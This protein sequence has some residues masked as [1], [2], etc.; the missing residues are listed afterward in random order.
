M[1]SIIIPTYNE[2]KNIKELIPNLFSERND[3]EVI[4]VDDNSPDGTGKTAENLAK[5]YNVKVISREEK[6]DLSS[7]V[8]DGFRVA[9]SDVIGVMDAD[10]SHPYSKIGE[11]IELTIDYDLVIGSRS[12][13]GGR[14][15]QWP[16]Y[17]KV[18]STTGK[19]LAKP[20]I[21][22][23]KDPLSGFFFMKKSVVRNINFNPIGYKILI[24]ILVK[25]SYRNV[26]EV[27]YVFSNRGVGSSKLN[28]K[29]H[30]NYLRHLKRLYVYKIK[31]G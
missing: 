10:L 14:V 23:I 9:S 24:E 25:G 8:V 22:N 31:N 20:L 4:I 1:V 16:W 17:R 19:I 13:R 30:T 27:P 18:M 21:N 3:L 28:M 11:L 7:A 5:K 12:I 2:K 29:E 15:E 26:I 6:L